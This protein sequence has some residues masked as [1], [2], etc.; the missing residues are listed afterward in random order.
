MVEYYIIFSLEIHGENMPV[1]GGDKYCEIANVIIT[2]IT[3]HYSALFLASLQT[4]CA[5]FYIQRSSE[6]CEHLLDLI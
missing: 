4:K 5:C 2:Y 6:G 1:I 3:V